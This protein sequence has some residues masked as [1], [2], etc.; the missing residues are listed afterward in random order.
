MP[1][2]LYH[3]SL[4]HCRRLFLY[5][6]EININIGVHDYE[7]T[8]EQLA[9]IYGISEKEVIDQTTQTALTLFKEL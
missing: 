3:P 2:Q 4:I 5:D 9:E 8:A 7:K 6:Y 1:A